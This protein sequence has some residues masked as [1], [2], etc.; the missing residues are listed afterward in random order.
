MLGIQKFL[1]LIVSLIMVISFVFWCISYAPS[2]RNKTAKRAKMRILSLVGLLIPLIV[3]LLLY[4][5]SYGLAT[6]NLLLK[7]AVILVFS[8]LTFNYVIKML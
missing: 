6:T 3:Y 8:S 1:N 2:K 4:A 5:K 7:G